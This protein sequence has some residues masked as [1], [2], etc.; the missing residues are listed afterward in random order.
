MRC[1]PHP[2]AGKMALLLALLT[3][4]LATNLAAQ[5]AVTVEAT[6]PVSTRG[7]GVPLVWTFT[8]TTTA[9]TLA[10]TFS[11]SG[12]AVAA[13]I[14]S[15]SVFIGAGAT[16]AFA[17]G[18][19][20]ATVSA[21]PQTTGAPNATPVS[22]IITIT[23]A[24]AGYTSPGGPATGYVLDN[25]NVVNSMVMAVTPQTTFINSASTA[26]QFGVYRSGSAALPYQ[27]SVT[28]TGTAT[29]G[30]TYTVTSTNLVRTV[31]NTLT[32]EM[33]AGATF[34][35]LTVTPVYSATATAPL[36]V[37]A[38]IVAPAAPAAYNT[39]IQNSATGTI[40]Y[41]NPYV[42]LLSPM[43][44]SVRE[45]ANT[46]IV[47]QVTRTGDTT[48]ALAVPFTITGQ[49]AEITVVTGAALT[50]V[51]AT[52]LG[53]LTLPAGSSTGLIQLFP[54]NDA[55]LTQASK[56]IT[57]TL[58]SPGTAFDPT[59]RSAT[60]I[61]DEANTF[62][63][64]SLTPDTLAETDGMSVFTVQ[65]SRTATGP[66][67]ALATTVT[68]TVGGTAVFGVDYT[69]AGTAVTYM[70]S[71]ATVSFLAN[72]NLA[73]FTMSPRYSSLITNDKT[74]VLSI[75]PG[76][77]LTTGVVT[78]TA[79]ITNTDGNNIRVAVTPISGVSVGDSVPLRFIFTRRTTSTAAFTFTFTVSGTAVFNTHYTQ[80]GAASFTATTGSLTFADGALEAALSISPRLTT[81]P[82]QDLTV[83]ISLTPN[84]GYGVLSPSSATGIIINNV[85]SAVSVALS[86]PFTPDDGNTGMT[87][88]FSRNG[89]TVDPLLVQFSVGGTALLS[90]PAAYSVFSIPAATWTFGGTST[91]TIPAGAASVS[92]FVTPTAGTAAA[93]DKTVVVTVTAGLAYTPSTTA[94][95]ATGTIFSNQGPNFVSVT[96]APTSQPESSLTPFVLSFR[97]SGSP[98]AAITVNFSVGLTA[99]TLADFTQIGAATFT[100][101]SGTVAIPAGAYTASVSV[102]PNNN[103]IPEPNKLILITVT[104]GVGYTPSTS[105]PVAATLTILND[106]PQ[107]SLSIVGLSSL[108]Q[109]IGGTFVF[110]FFRPLA[111]VTGA[112]S[113]SYTV[114]GT[115]RPGVDYTAVGPNAASFPQTLGANGVAIIPDGSQVVVI[116]LSPVDFRGPQAEKTISIQLVSQATYFI[117]TPAAAVATITNPYPTQ[118][119]LAVSPST[120]TEGAATT[121]VFTVTRLGSTSAD[122][123]VSF[124]LSG[125]AGYTTDYTQ[126]GASS[127]T[128]ATLSGTVVI[129]AGS[130]TATITVTLVDDSVIEADETITMSI[131]PTASYTVS[132]VS[133]A[134]V[135][136][137]DNDGVTLSL[138]VSPIT[139]VSF[140]SSVTFT[141]SRA[142]GSGADVTATFTLSGSA[143]INQHYTLVGAFG[144]TGPYTIFIP[145]ASSSVTLVA[146]P[147]RTAT[148]SFAR[149]I[150]VSLQ[151]GTG[152]QLASPSSVTG[153][154]QDPPVLSPVVTVTSNVA[155]LLDSINNGASFVYRIPAALTSEL[156]VNFRVFGNAT[157][158]LDYTITNSRAS[159]LWNPDRN[160][161][162]LSTLVIPAGAVAATVSLV[163]L[164]PISAAAV[165]I[166]VEVANP[167][168][169]GVYTI[170]SPSTASITLLRDASA[171]LTNQGVFG[172]TIYSVRVENL[173][174]TSEPNDLLPN[175]KGSRPSTTGGLKSRGRRAV[176]AVDYVVV[177]SGVLITQAAAFLGISTQYLRVSENFE[178]SATLQFATIPNG[179]T[180]AV[181]GRNFVLAINSRAPG[182]ANSTYAFATGFMVGLLPDQ[183]KIPARAPPIVIPQINQY[184]NVYVPEIR[185]VRLNA[186]VSMQASAT[187]VAAVALIGVLLVGTIF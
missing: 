104:T 29:F 55:V 94:A 123:S 137:K 77:Y 164:A 23:G 71:T 56:T 20:T 66:A 140:P 95:T 183:T 152:Y 83:I 60:I 181:L 143:T 120:I 125:S 133:S 170:G 166:S 42:R 187:M 31:T 84:A 100:A 102:T 111:A 62:T 177:S 54:I 80:V 50:Y 36:T 147:I 7:S 136:V 14:S 119:S 52:G 107:V 105:S 154:I 73:V 103:D 15:T 19:A 24:G 172:G 178:R 173:G 64:T 81:V 122:L 58:S 148:L 96:A 59:P 34:V 155:T 99:A 27:L 159:V 86:P 1:L 97:R 132:G 134:T 30:T 8:R 138:G 67:L 75:A 167:T 90:M 39:G 175:V 126:V 88:T 17:A 89:R 45:D 32:V 9:G 5:P 35:P 12:T 114:G 28:F 149:S 43:P 70:T 157:L 179:V 37:I 116:Q 6:T 61:D 38:T 115:A 74:I 91:I 153:L 112:L 22:I 146:T 4:S 158:N 65:I 150:V 78:S 109:S 98:A 2:V 139:A 93:G 68:L 33:P 128:V 180:N 18:Q 87:F 44:A 185:P 82:G 121:A 10:V 101:T 57:V 72:Q 47:F 110:Q 21:L 118:V 160:R 76:N 53:T 3:L 156:L 113:V 145:G 174:L 16:V 131:I 163:P 25:V 106:D 129:P 127:F 26:L 169:S 41:D 13:D 168:V 63:I 142:T 144:G 165:G 69:V 162:L 135:T 40:S 85:P 182:L 79:T 186:A 124:T 46:A 49:I 161:V 151:A 184:I 108:S 176:E 117:A 48:A 171:P 141:I 92:V 130:T 51:P 11:A